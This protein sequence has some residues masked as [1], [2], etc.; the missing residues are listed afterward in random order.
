MNYDEWSEAYDCGYARGMNRGVFFGI[1]FAIVIL[2]VLS[3]IAHCQTLT[4]RV[5]LRLERGRNVNAILN[6]PTPDTL[7]LSVVC[8]RSRV[9]ISNMDY[10]LPYAWSPVTITCDSTQAQS[11]VLTAVV[12]AGNHAMACTIEGQGVSGVREKTS[13]KDG[14]M[15]IAPL[16]DLTGRAVRGV[17]ASGIYWQ[18]GKRVSIIK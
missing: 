4:P 7:R 1:A 12:H 13:A 8:D 14:A 5:S 10:C 2:S 6:N 16:Y 9:R 11:W 15:N 18:D 3:S 17:P